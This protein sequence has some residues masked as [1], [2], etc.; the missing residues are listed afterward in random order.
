[1]ETV[2]LVRVCTALETNRF[3]EQRTILLLVSKCFDLYF[4]RS[5]LKPVDVFAVQ[6]LL[7][8]RS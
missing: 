5:S 1:M 2:V 4:K 6:G 3:D 7:I 8:S